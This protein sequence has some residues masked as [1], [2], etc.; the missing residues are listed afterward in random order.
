VEIFQPNNH[1]IWAIAYRKVSDE[2]R[3]LISSLILSNYSSLA[4]TVL[5]VEQVN[6]VEIASNNFKVVVEKNHRESK[7]LFRVYPQGSDSA[8]IK[9]VIKAGRFLLED[10]VKVSVVIASDCGEV[11]L[12]SRGFH[13]MAFE[14]IE[15]NHFRG[16]FQELTSVARGIGEMFNKLSQLTGLKLSEIELKQ[17]K[18]RDFEFFKEAWV[19]LFPIVER[20]HLESPDETS[21][22]L[23]E[24]K[25]LILES[26]EEMEVL[27][28]SLVQ[29]AHYDLHPHNLLTDGGSLTAFL[30]LDS[31]GP[32]Q[33][34]EAITFALHRLVRQ[35]IVHQKPVDVAAVVEKGKSIF[36][37]EYL[38]VNDLTQKE[39]S[40][41]RTLIVHRALKMLTGIVKDYYVNG[42]PSWK[43][44]VKKNISSILEAVYF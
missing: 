26:V 33:R 8:L 10:G 32:L 29:T 30:D 4:D 2:K 7:I 9:E 17:S 12:S 34:M 18:T 39:I 42:D 27:P 40:G 44:D 22:L 15:G 31:L 43:Q 36:L 25:G 16:T 11:L 14:F 35:C 1:S 21:S 3:K 13:Y 20:K 38:A 6:E 19:E 37:N 41:L 28:S 24:H 23:L 5:S